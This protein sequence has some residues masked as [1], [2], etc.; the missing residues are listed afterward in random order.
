MLG[1]Y[2]FKNVI[3]AYYENKELLD[4]YIK[5]DT[6]E[7]LNDRV[8][9]LGIDSRTFMILAMVYIAIWLWALIATITLWNK[10]SVVAQVFAVLGLLFPSL[11][12]LITLL[13]VYISYAIENNGKNKRK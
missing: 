10:I 11:G 1:K 7:G 13:S 2:S 6:Y 8:L 4:S 3:N 5:G 9:I 12:P